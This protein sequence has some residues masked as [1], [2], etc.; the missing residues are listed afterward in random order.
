MRPKK[1]NET[2]VRTSFSAEYV[3]GVDPGFAGR[4][5]TGAVNLLGNETLNVRVP[6]I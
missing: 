6:W 2:I 3:L 4:L 1:V 5:T